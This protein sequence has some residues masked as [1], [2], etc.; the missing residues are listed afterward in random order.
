MKLSH[1]CA[2]IALSCT[3]STAFA[4][5]TT[6]DTSDLQALIAVEMAQNVENIYATQEAEINKE[7]QTLVEQSIKQETAASTTAMTE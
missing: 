1:L 5:E 4:S 7:A 2:I 6:V 3:A